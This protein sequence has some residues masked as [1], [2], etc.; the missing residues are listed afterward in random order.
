MAKQHRWLVS[1][2]FDVE[3]EAPNASFA[4]WSAKYQVRNMR[5]GKVSKAEA[6]K[7]R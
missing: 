3:V 4:I 2:T 1:L 7:G 6:I 5:G